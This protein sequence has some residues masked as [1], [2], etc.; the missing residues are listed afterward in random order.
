VAQQ[1]CATTPQEQQL[2]QL[3]KQIGL[4]QLSPPVAGTL[5]HYLELLLLPLPH[6]GEL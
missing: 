5:S 4:G 2:K 1:A 6:V 3:Q